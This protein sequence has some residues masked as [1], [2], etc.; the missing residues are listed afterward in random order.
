MKLKYKLDLQYFGGRGSA[1]ASGSSIFKGQRGGS[2]NAPSTPDLP[3]KM[4]KLYNG[5]KMS[6]QH[7]VSTFRSEHASSN[8]EH[9][10]IYDDDGF[11]SIYKHGG[12]SSVGWTADELTGGHLV[13]NHPSGSNFSRADL[14]TWSTTGIKSITASST[15][16]DYTVTKGSHFNSSGFLKGI[17]NAKSNKSNYNDAVDEWL[18]ANQ[19]KYGYTY[20]VKNY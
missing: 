9:A 13:H 18:K 16:V 7:T 17:N 20:K 14:D 15:K 2:G 12:K 3:A 8:T 6:A 19:K 1:S 10:I 4:N 11:V 5:N